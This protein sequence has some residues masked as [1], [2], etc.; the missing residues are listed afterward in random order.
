MLL[1]LGC[2]LFGY[3]LHSENVRRKVE[4]TPGKWQKESLHSGS[5]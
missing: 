1:R 2:E 3:K 4:V 5:T